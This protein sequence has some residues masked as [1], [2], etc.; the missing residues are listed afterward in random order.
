MFVL[1]NLLVGS[2]VLIVLQL[3]AL[4]CTYLGV[5]TGLYGYLNFVWILF[6][7][8]FVWVSVVRRKIPEV[9]C[10]KLEPFHIKKSH[11]I[12]NKLSGI[13]F[14]YN[15]KFIGLSLFLHR[16]SKIQILQ[17]IG[18]SWKFSRNRSIKFCDK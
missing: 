10:F 3:T 16:H 13:K 17:A 1:Y 4:L 12:Y 8:R 9:N 18:W 2:T 6:S 7:G 15:L 5:N 14:F 11:L